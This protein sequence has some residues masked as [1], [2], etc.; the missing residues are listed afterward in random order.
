MSQNQ[1]ISNAS[2]K[3]NLEIME[4]DQWLSTLT[5]TENLWDFFLILMSN[6]H[7]R[8]NSSESQ[9]VGPGHEYFFRFS[10]KFQCIA[11]VENHWNETI[12]GLDP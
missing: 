6:L 3:K 7:L 9:G 4:L 2:L 12:K 11:K 5:E 8:P 1:I 10:Q